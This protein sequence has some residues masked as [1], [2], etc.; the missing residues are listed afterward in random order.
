MRTPRLFARPK[1]ALAAA[2]GGRWLRRPTVARRSS[3]PSVSELF[4]LAALPTLVSRLPDPTILE[5]NDA[6]VE[7][8]GYSREEVIG[9]NAAEIGFERSLER[10]ARAREPA[11][12]GLA[13]RDAESVLST[14][15]GTPI[16]VVTR[17]T[18]VTIAG[19]P[20]AF[21]VFQDITALRAREQD[22]RYQEERVRVALEQGH[23]GAWEF[24]PDTGRAFRSAEHL[25]L[26]GASPADSGWSLETFLARVL[27]EDRARVEGRIRAAMERGESWELECRIL[28]TDGAV[29]WVFIAGG[30]QARNP[31][32]GPRMAGIVQDITDRKRA[33]AALVASEREFHELAEAMPQIV[34]ACDAQGQFTYFNRQWVDY[35]GLAMEASLGQGWN[36]PFHPEDRQRAWDAWRQAVAGQGDYSLECRLRRWDGSYRWWLARGVPQVDGAGQVRKWFGTCTDIDELK[37]TEAE[38]LSLETQL[39][40]LQRMEAVGRLAGGVAHD[41]NNVLAAILAAATLL[42]LESGPAAED[43]QVIERAALRGRDLLKGL[44]GLVRNEVQEV[45]PIDLN[46]LLTQDAGL[47]SKTTL[48]R[49]RLVLDLDP[50]LPTVMGAP[51]AISTAI[52]NLCVNALDAMPEG[53]T[54]TLR[55]RR[56]S[57]GSVQVEVQDTGQGMPPAVLQRAMDPYFTTKPVG[58]GTGLGLSI[59]FRVVE[60]HGG[61]IHLQSEVGQG[62]LVRLTLPVDPAGAGK[63]RRPVD[64][65][66][67]QARRP[68]AI[69]LVDDDPLILRTVPGMLRSLGHQVE[70]AAGGG[71][72]LALLAAGGAWEVIL[73]DLN[74]PGMNGL[75]ALEQIRARR[76]D[77]PVLVTSGYADADMRSRLQQYARVGFLAKP[78]SPGEIQQALEAFL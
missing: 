23:I 17:S 29:R 7:L 2:S 16:Q 40:H 68:L 31:Q 75:Q 45:E 30:R 33:E 19:R 57:P 11:R 49:V 32:S 3:E 38:R 59:V 42:R 61:A 74:M 67:V 21:T 10:R 5:V 18:P 43:A 28:R 14:K 27:P 72:A 4:N 13:T 37:R 69:L 54:L 26:F 46:D 66:A 15:A 8:F 1:G 47:L 50:G 60:S 77:L 76:P 53:G 20:C 35:T 44:M 63:G 34:W 22:L 56:I 39:H 70:S 52:M 62:T 36:R 51:P 24:E 25:K 71:A 65:A 6:W 9:R 55:T 48:E 78:Y 73:L 58:K 64:E 41:M 12:A